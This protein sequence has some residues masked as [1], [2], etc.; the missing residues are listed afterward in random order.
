MPLVVDRPIF[1]VG[2]ERS[3]TTLLRLMLDHHPMIAFNGESEYIVSRISEDG[4]Y[5]E[6]SGYRAWLRSD[7]IFQG[8][9]LRVDESL[10]YPSLVNDF[11]DQFR[12]RSRKAMVG[13]TVHTQFHKLHRIW[14]RAKY[15]YL[16]RDGRDVAGSVQRMGWAGNAYVAADWWL[17]A[18]AEWD[19]LRAVLGD[20]DWIE[21]RFED[22]AADAA[23]QL[24]RICAFIDAPYSDQMLGYVRDSTYGAPDSGSRFRWRTAMGMAEV[25]RLEDKLGER[26]PLRGYEL[27]GHPRIRVAEWMKICLY[28]HSRVRAFLFRLNRYGIVL[29]IQEALARRLGFDRAHRNAISRINRIINAHLK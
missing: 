18:E 15:I 5:P 26:L 10:D 13:A 14:P 17:G 3:G 12:S 4:A 28:L 22:L 8:S 11:L 16:L 7:R 9:C 23:A 25:Q 24:R 21:V 19:A 20:D 6:M 1:L 29:T 27:S 2:A